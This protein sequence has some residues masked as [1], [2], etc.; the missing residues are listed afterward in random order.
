VLRELAGILGLFLKPAPQTDGGG[1]DKLTDELMQ[2][3]IQIRAEARAKKDFAT[4]DLIRNS[5]TAAGW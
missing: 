2:L 4:A 5:L 3:L 1:D